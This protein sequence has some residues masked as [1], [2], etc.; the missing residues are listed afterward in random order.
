[1]RKDGGGAYF[2]SDGCSGYHSACSFSM[3]SSST[4]Y[5][6]DSHFTAALEYHTTG[7]GAILPHGW[8]WWACR[9]SNAWKSCFCEQILLKARQEVWRGSPA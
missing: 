9:K 8:I 1:M 6:T 4:H 3:S 5:S 7:I 2:V